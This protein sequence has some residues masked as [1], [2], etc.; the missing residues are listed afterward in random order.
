MTLKTMCVSNADCKIG[1]ALRRMCNNFEQTAVGLANSQVFCALDVGSFSSAS[2]QP[3][4]CTKGSVP[5][6]WLAFP[7]V[8]PRSWTWSMMKPSNNLFLPYSLPFISSFPSGSRHAVYG[9]LAP[10]WHRRRLSCKQSD[11]LTP[12][13]DHPHTTRPSSSV[14]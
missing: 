3:A 4:H 1:L 2:Q 5:W 12:A 11:P 9:L 6:H 13:T 8:R 7:R 10:Q 14:F